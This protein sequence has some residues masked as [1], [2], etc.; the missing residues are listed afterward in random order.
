MFPI[1]LYVGKLDHA[2]DEELRFMQG[3]EYEPETTDG[4]RVS[5][6]R[7]ILHHPRLTRL[8]RVVES[9]LN[10]Y[11]KAVMCTDNELYITQSWTNRNAKSSQHAAHYHANS[12]LSGTVYLGVD[13]QVAPIVFKSDRK[14]AIQVGYRE[15][16]PYT[17]DTFSF[18][19]RTSVI[20][21]F[22][23]TIEHYVP[24]NQSDCTRLSLA[25]NTFVRGRLGRDMMLTELSLG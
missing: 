4:N 3:V 10:T 6:D 13:E 9:H 19:P 8:R 23:S 1:P 22:P 20:V 21:L 12:V 25:F 16:N 11:R 15:Q 2:F 14:S 7:R 5:K 17:A 18:R 24:V